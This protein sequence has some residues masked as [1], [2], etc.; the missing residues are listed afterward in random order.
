MICFELILNLKL[1]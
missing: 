1:L